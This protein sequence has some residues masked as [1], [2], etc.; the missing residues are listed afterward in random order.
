MNSVFKNFVTR[1]LVFSSV[2]LFVGIALF[3]MVLMKYYH[4][5]YVFALLLFVIL[6]AVFHYVFVKYCEKHP[7]RFAGYF[8]L[9]T[10]VKML[11]CLLYLLLYVILV[12][13]YVLVFVLFFF[14]MYVCFS[15]FEVV[16]L[17]NHF[18]KEK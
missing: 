5:S 6:T 7:K 3:S 11:I 2:I 17:L 14:A 18:N 12:K 4:I 8:M 9:A 16:S 1:L 13:K 10:T 15:I